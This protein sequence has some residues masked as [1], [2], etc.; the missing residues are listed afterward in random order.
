VEECR[1]SDTGICAGTVLDVTCAFYWFHSLF[2]ALSQSDYKVTRYQQLFSVDI[3]DILKQL[4]LRGNI[5]TRLIQ[6]S[7]YAGVNID[8]CPN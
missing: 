8:H 3:D 7:A 6:C 5:S 1:E 2:C 4:E